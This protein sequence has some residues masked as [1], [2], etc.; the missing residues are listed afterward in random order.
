MSE[1]N[2]EIQGNDQRLNS[3]KPKT[4]Y[5]RAYDAEM[6]SGVIMRVLEVHISDDAFSH[7]YFRGIPE[8]Y[9]GGAVYRENL[10]ADFVGDLVEPTAEP[11][12]AA[13]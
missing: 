8:A 1:F 9:K 10:P 5:Q 12:E 11:G 4:T 2:S 13:A 6:A 3:A 7:V